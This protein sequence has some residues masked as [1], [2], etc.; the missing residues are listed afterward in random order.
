MMLAEN[1]GMSATSYLPT[2]SDCHRYIMPYDKSV[3]FNCPNCSVDLIWR[4]QSSRQ[5]VRD[6]TCF[7]CN[8]QGP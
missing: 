6:Y 5:A 7:S 3:K 8:F 2:C 1:R 4:C